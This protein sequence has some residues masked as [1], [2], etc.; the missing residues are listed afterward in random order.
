MHDT[1]TTI[2]LD[3]ERL[4][5]FIRERVEPFEGSP[6]LRRIDGGQ[7]NPTFIVEAGK[8]RYVLRQKPLGALPSAHA[9]DREFR[10]LAALAGTA[11]PVPRARVLCE[12]PAVLG[13]TFYLMDFVEG[14]ILTDQTLPGMATSERKAIYEELTRVLAALHGVDYRAIGLV[15]YGREGQYLERQI[16]RW[17]RQ[18]RA[19]ETR[20]IEPMERLIEW[21]PVHVPP[22]QET[23]VVHG[24]YRLDNVILHPAEPRI[25]AVLDWELST[26]GD[27]LVDFAYFCMSWRLPLGTRRTLAGVDVA[28]LGIPREDEVVA[29][30]CARTGRGEGGR[31][32]YWAFYHAFN[33]FRMAC[34]QQGIARRALDGNAASSRAQ[35]AA[36]RVEASAGAGWE[37]AQQAT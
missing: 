26:L 6:A 15:D 32:P 28:P 37:M 35:A 24:D 2:G 31:I 30:Y 16:E 23:S 9:V 27:P 5:A 13:T 20:R 36:A 10:V 8:Q 14:R 18:Y 21:L 4:G 22:Q 3:A 7:S 12:D 34:I 17:T 19:S 25:I 1:G 29:A 11:V 33:M